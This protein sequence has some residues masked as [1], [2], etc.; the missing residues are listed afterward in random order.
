MCSKQA[1]L[2]MQTATLRSWIGGDVVSHEHRVLSRCMITLERLVACMVAR[3]GV[4]GL[5]LSSE[6][7][8]DFDRAWKV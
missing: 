4:G 6:H 8:K 1:C 3:A 2:G 5:Q 7:T